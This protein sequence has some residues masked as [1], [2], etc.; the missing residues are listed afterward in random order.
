[1]TELLVRAT[2]TKFPDIYTYKKKVRT[3]K[4]YEA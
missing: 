4:E 2:E 3:E 1:M